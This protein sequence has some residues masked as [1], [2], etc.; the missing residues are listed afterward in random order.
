MLFFALGS[1][2]DP[3]TALGALWS[4][5][6]ELGPEE[7]QARAPAPWSSVADQGSESTRPAPS[8]GQDWQGGVKGSVLEELRTGEETGE[9]VEGE[10]TGHPGSLPR[11]TS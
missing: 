4:P 7:A 3:H 8:G 6:T 2:I 10:G 9:P 1:R 11:A 5:G